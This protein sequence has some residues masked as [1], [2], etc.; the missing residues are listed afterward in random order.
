MKYL[1]LSSNNANNLIKY[2]NIPAS[3]CILQNPIDSLQS[4]SDIIIQLSKVDLIVF[5]YKLSPTYDLI[6]SV[7]NQF[8]IPFIQ[9]DDYV[10]SNLKLLSNYLSK[11]TLQTHTTLKT[12]IDSYIE[13]IQ[14]NTTFNPPILDYS[15]F[16]SNEFVLKKVLLDLKIPDGLLT[17]IPDVVFTVPDTNFAIICSKH[18][19]SLD[20]TI[21]SIIN[22]HCIKINRFLQGKDVTKVFNNDKITHKVFDN[23]FFAYKISGNYQ[24]RLLL[25]Y[26]NGLELHKI[27]IK[28][29]GKDI[30]S[31]YLKAFTDYV[32]NYK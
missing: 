11:F 3:D 19:N 12:I 17:V 30:T 23:Y 4:F 10:L 2:L 7:C 1:I 32:K 22:K 26:K 8:K 29:G 24:I 5:D 25:R 18:Y 27:Y 13:A 31:E 9:S 28:N 15:V 16:K 6:M 14:S 20:K 21:K